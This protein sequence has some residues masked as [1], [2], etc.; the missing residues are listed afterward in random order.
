[1][2]ECSH[3]FERECS[4]P[5]IIICQNICGFVLDCG[6]PCQGICS[7]CRNQ[8]FHEPCNHSAAIMDSNKN[9]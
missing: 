6:H 1:M 4:I 2:P 5:K 3:E 7:N 8:I 9:M